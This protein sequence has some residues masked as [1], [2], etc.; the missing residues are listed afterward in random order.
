LGFV[1]VTQ[2]GSLC[3][4]CL[5][6]YAINLLLAIGFTWLAHA[7]PNPCSWGRLLPSWP[8]LR[9][10]EGAPGRAAA[11]LKLGGTLVVLAG[12]VTAFVFGYSSVADSRDFSN[13]QLAE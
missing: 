8:G 4:R 6:T 2:I 11:W 10:R 13:R 5:S 9:R 12:L 1:M 7:L 3:G